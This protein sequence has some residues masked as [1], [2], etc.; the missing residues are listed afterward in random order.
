MNLVSGLAHYKS[1]VSK[2]FL[3]FHAVKA[4]GRS[5]GRHGFRRRANFIFFIPCSCHSHI[6]FCATLIYFLFSFLLELI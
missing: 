3:S 4:P 5:S 1:S 2:W 6:V